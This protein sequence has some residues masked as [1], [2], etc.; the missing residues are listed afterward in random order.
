[1]KDEFL[2]IVSHELRTPL[3]AVVG[4]A[5]I[6][7]ERLPPGPEAAKPLEIIQRNAR[8]QAKMID[9]I[10]DVSRIVSGKVRLEPREVRLDAIIGHVVETTRPAADAKGIT[11]GRTLDPDV[12]PLMLDP[13]RIQQVVWN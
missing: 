11:V 13:D 3:N 9:D 5:S 1:M 10:L 2:A 6:L 4:W 8:L 7:A 12:P